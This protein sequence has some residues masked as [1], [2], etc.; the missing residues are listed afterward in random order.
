HVKR[1]ANAFIL[2][3]KAHSQAISRV[4]GGDNGQISAIA[5]KMWKEASAEVKDEFYQ[6]AKEEKE[7][8]AKL[9]PG[10]K[11]QP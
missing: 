9:N 6:R 8:H 7:R 11:Y 1:P 2:F 10:Y 3:R 4:V 5:G